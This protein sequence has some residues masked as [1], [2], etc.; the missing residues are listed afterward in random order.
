[1]KTEELLKLKRQLFYISD[2][3][4]VLK[5]RGYGSDKDTLTNLKIVE[6]VD[7]MPAEY[8]TWVRLSDKVVRLG[9]IL[10]KGSQFPL[11]DFFECNSMG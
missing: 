9:Q 11:W 1:M 10:K 6:Y 4:S 8:G 3:L 7:F 2:K 5:G